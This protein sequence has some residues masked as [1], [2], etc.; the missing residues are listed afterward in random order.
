MNDLLII[1]DEKLILWGLKRDLER[2]GYRVWAFP[3]CEE[4]METIERQHFKVA[5]V[6]VRL[7][8]AGGL[9]IL[10]RIKQFEPET[11]VIM[12]TA[13]ADVEMAVNSI[14]KGAFDFVLKPFSLEKIHLTIQN[15][16][17]ATRLKKEVESLKTEIALRQRKFMMQGKSP[18][19]RKVIDSIERIGKAG[20]G[21]VL[22]CG[23][24]G[25]GKG[26][27]ANDIHQIG[28]RSSGPFIEINCGAI[29]EN[30]FES[31][32][33][34]HEKGSFTGASDLKKG[35]LEL[36]D[37]GTIF[38]DEVAE[39]PLPIQAKFLKAL[40]EQIIWRV[41][42]RRPIKVDVNII[43][44]TNR[45]LS[46]MVREGAFRE[47]LFYRLN[48]V[49]IFIPPLRDREN[50]IFLLAEHFR[51]NL[52]LKYKR[53]FSNFSEE[54]LR[55]MKNYSWPGNIRELRNSIERAIILESSDVIQEESL[56][57]GGMALEPML[58]TQTV[59]GEEPE[60][61]ETGLNLLGHLEAIEKK[62]LEK[63]ML[64]CA[65]NQSQAA[66]LLGMSRDL[67]RYRL[68]KYDLLD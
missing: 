37:E 47:D 31:E 32:L 14:R 65:D 45:D 63:A 24:S 43:A 41:G 10:E 59:F 30:L 39:M 3:S 62:Y 5:L 33:F 2:T 27:A 49:P 18:M 13:F 34:G 57:L 23:E 61:P 1:D 19:M 4:A 20:A 7:P 50:D 8:G 11:Q 16:L 36:A 21:V 28:P 51:E 66:K 64:E 22:I 68:K 15:A 42:G 60:I 52:Q 40:E 53:V 29:P 54:A 17:E 26:V 25:T 67:L 35:L 48:V 6:D 46:Q 38:L 44:A 9:A 12:I 55:R 56:G 58:K